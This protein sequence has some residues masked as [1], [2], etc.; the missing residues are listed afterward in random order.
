MRKLTEIDNLKIELQAMRNTAN[1]YK[2]RVQM[3]EYVLLGVMHSVDKWLDGDELEQDEVNR[4]AT[5]REKTLQIVESKQAEIERLQRTT[6]RLEKLAELRKTAGFKKLKECIELQ[7]KNAELQH[8]IS[9]CKAEA[10]KEYMER[11]K[12]G[13]IEGGIYPVLVKN[14]LDRVKKEMVGECK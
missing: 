4:A 11:V 12:T 1:S 13:L 2:E 8:E 3:L 14:T 7:R 6:T 5:M 9:S 10:I